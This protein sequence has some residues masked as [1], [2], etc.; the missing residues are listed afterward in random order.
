MRK[1]TSKED[2]TKALL[3]YYRIYGVPQ[4]KVDAIMTAN[5]GNLE[6]YLA[7]TPELMARKLYEWTF[8]E[9]MH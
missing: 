8:D 1:M 5:S 4:E 7:A 9:E 2:F 3:D 6:T